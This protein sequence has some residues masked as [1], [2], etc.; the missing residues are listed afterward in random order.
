MLSIIYLILGIAA[1]AGA[2]YYIRTVIVSKNV[3]SAEQKAEAVITEARK[4]EKEIL[5]QA[6]DKALHI[7]DDGKREEQ[8]RRTELQQYQQ[9]LEK[10]E[11][12][13]DQKLLELENKQQHLDHKT[14][15]V[16]EQKEHILKIK[17]D[18]LE[19]LERIAGLTKDDA[20]KALMTN[21][22]L[23]YKD[24]L[25]ARMK[26]L[27]EENASELE[28]KAKNMLALTIA[29][30]SLSHVSEFTTT[31]VDLP[32]EDMKGRIIGKEGR[33]IRALEH[34][35]GCEIVIDD[36]PNTIIISGFSPIRRHVAKRSLETL[37]SD[38]RIHPG[39]IE[40]AVEQ[41]KKNIAAEIKKAG[42]DALYERGITGVDPKLVQILGRLK[43]RT[44]YGQNVLQ[45]SMEVSYI[46]ELLAR[47]LGADVNVCK[48]G[49]LFHDIGKAVDHEVQ[50]GHPEI[51]YDIMIKFGFPEEMAYMSPAHHEDAPKTLEGVIVKIADAISGSRPGARNDSSEQYLQRLEELEGIATR[52]E[53]VQKAYAIQ[54][55]RELRVFVSADQIDD[56]GAQKM[57]RDIAKSIESEMTYPGEI[58]VTLIREKRVIEVAR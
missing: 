3:N 40:D 45:H 21:V 8:Q 9:R 49:G 56:L 29:R 48:K 24:D 22:E 23:Q 14:K 28:R 47:E 38:G 43:F 36:T 6:N 52:H 32:S 16:E 12:T 53:G 57:A 30:T 26:K 2:G 37:I 34:L 35:T 39:R 55:G 33:N 20:Q 11:S 25:L 4:K 7:I 44:S 58:K 18:Q 46:S 42:E 41:A 1:G 51:G 17:Q 5:L 19:K 15:E 31:T 10:R 27:Q 13:F 54:A 50:G